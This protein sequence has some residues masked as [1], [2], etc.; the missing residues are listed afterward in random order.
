MLCELSDASSSLG[1]F[2]L[3]DVADDG[4]L[5]HLT[6]WL[7]V[8]DGE[9]SPLACIDSLQRAQPQL[10]QRTIDV[11]KEPQSLSD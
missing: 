7:D 8:A 6:H 10:H 4:T 9:C 3:L 11:S 1:E 5:W 2:Y